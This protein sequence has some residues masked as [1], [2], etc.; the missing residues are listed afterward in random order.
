MSRGRVRWWS[1]QLAVQAEVNCVCW[2]SRR[3]NAGIHG[4]CM[5]GVMAGV[6]WELW[7]ELAGSYGGSK[8]GVMAGVSWESRRELAG[9]HGE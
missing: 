3:V 1:Q 2:E 4:W 6:S 9:S 7:L 8:L 5:L